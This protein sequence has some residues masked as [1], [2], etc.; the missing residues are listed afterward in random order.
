MQ[1]I[2][3]RDGKPFGV[4]TIDS[5]TGRVTFKPRDGC[6]DMA[7]RTWASLE[8]C[9]RAVAKESRVLAGTGQVGVASSAGLVH[10]PP[11]KVMSFLSF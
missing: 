4:A 7:K 2:F 11:K 5:K 1:T 3:D 9:R 8:A 6:E 10:L